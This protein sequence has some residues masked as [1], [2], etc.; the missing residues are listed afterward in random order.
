MAATLTVGVVDDIDVDDIDV[1]DDVAAY[2]LPPLL[3]NPHLVAPGTYSTGPTQQLPDIIQTDDSPKDKAD[4]MKQVFAAVP[5]SF[6]PTVRFH[7][8]TPSPS[9]TDHPARFYVDVH[10]RAE[11][12][13][14]IFAYV[15][16]HFG[17]EFSA[18]FEAWVLRDIE[19]VNRY[20]ANGYAGLVITELSDKVPVR[21]NVAFPHVGPNAST[22]SE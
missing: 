22:K 15:D 13:I 5:D 14:E 12:L 8:I 19:N 6:K 7:V 21:A 16:E 1:A 3:I 17:A 2:I 10:S 20:F 11:A 18:R 4:L 9:I